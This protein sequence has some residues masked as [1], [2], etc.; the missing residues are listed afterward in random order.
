MANDLAIPIRANHRRWRALFAAVGQFLFVAVGGTLAAVFVM[1]IPA[2]TQ[3]E[4]WTADIR[5]IYG[6]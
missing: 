1:Q 6:P 3:V 4:Q 5:M 2:F